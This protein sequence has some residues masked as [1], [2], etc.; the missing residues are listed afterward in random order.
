[1]SQK[2]FGGKC[3]FYIFV[4][5]IFCIYWFVI[6]PLLWICVKDRY[7][8]QP[9]QFHDNWQFIYW[10]IAFIVFVVILLV[11]SIIATFCCDVKRKKRSDQTYFCDV[12]IKEVEVKDEKPKPAIRNLNK[13]VEIIEMEQIHQQ[14]IPSE[15]VVLRDNKTIKIPLRTRKV[16][17]IEISTQTDE[18]HGFYGSLRSPITPREQFFFSNRYSARGPSLSGDS[19]FCNYALTPKVHSKLIK[20]EELL[21]TNKDLYNFM[22]KK[23]VDYKSIEEFLTNERKCS[24]IPITKKKFFIANVSP[25]QTLKSEIFLCVQED[26]TQSKQKSLKIAELIN[27]GSVTFEDDVFD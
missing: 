7:K 3:C 1:M 5:L 14:K 26:A 22:N 12:V 13:D 11:P 9:K 23:P 27:S 19:T 24:E 20:D 16:D 10:L 15:P 4:L 21:E 6:T 8:Q 25:R 18:D 2:I 17:S